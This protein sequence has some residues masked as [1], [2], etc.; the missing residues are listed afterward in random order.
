[1]AIKGECITTFRHNTP[2]NIVAIF[3][4]KYYIKLV[5]KTFIEK[6]SSTFLQL[7]AKN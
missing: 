2:N 7:Q 5:M 6:N 4:V 3:T 1:M